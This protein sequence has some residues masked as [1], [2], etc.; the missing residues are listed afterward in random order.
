MRA[1]VVVV[2]VFVGACNARESRQGIPERSISEASLSLAVRFGDRFIAYY[3]REVE[4]EPDAVNDETPQIQFDAVEGP[5]AA[6]DGEEHV[7]DLSEPGP[8]VAIHNLHYGTGGGEDGLE[9]AWQVLRLES[10]VD[11][12]SGALLVSGSPNGRVDSHYEVHFEGTYDLPGVGPIEMGV[13]F[14]NTGISGAQFGVEG[15]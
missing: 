7:I 4:L 1:L 6:L 2:L 11:G 9:T 12:V 14:A 5:L 3:G 10:G 13:A 15:E 8:W